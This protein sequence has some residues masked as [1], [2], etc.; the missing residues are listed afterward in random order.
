MPFVDLHALTSGGSHAAA[1]LINTIAA[2]GDGQATAGVPIGPAA[3]LVGW[4]NGT[5]IADTIESIQLQSQDMWDP[6]NG[7]NYNLGTSGLT[8]LY[9][10]FTNVPYRTGVR[11]FTG[12]QNTGAA[13]TFVYTLDLYSEGNIGARYPAGWGSYHPANKI[14]LSTTYGGALTAITWG[15]QA[16]AP[17][18]A[19]PNG[20]Y[21][22]E[23][24]YCNAMTNYG[25]LRFR[26]AD[27]G[28]AAP[29]FPVYDITNTTVANAVQPKD[30]FLVYQGYQFKRLSEMMGQPCAPRFRVTNAGTGLR[31]E[32]LDIVA[33]TPIVNIIISKVGDL[34]GL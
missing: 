29:G 27:F 17:T 6:I 28:G 10:A 32:M 14:V 34:Q 30:Q 24:A 33:D 2:G 8:G 26:H 15:A 3:T 18:T 9:C 23:G 12:Q 25:L 21:E 31:F 16:F 13:N 4:G 20:I 11:N 5:T 19:I 22:I 1:A 7:E